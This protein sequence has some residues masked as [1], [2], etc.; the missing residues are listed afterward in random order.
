MLSKAA[1]K[2]HFRLCILNSS[3]SISA[4]GDYRKTMRHHQ[5]FS[6]RLVL[7][8]SSLSKN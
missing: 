4:P 5:A 8:C 2:T 7:A 1:A 6:G 3:K